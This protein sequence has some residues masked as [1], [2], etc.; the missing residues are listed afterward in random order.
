MSIIFGAIVDQAHLCVAGAH[1]L[2]ATMQYVSGA[3]R[4]P[5]THCLPIDT[6]AH[7]QLLNGYKVFLSSIRTAEN[8][9][10]TPH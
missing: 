6:Q 7:V 1:M 10:S 5:H 3:G 2:A 8:K 9:S 4:S